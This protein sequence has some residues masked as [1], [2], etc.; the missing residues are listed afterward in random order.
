MHITNFHLGLKDR[1]KKA[2]LS[3]KKERD[4]NEKLKQELIATNKVDEPAL[5]KKLTI[6]RDQFY[7]KAYA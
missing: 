6:E 3:L 1:I 2:K 7:D 4:D 5:K